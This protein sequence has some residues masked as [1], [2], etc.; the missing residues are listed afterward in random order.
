MSAEAPTQPLFDR[1]DLL[2]LVDS[3]DDPGLDAVALGVIGFDADQR[4]RRYNAFESQASGLEAGE[5]LGRPLFTEI[6]QCMNNYL[7]AERFEAART[8][9]H[10]LDE[11]ID[12]VLTWRM[13]P[14]KVRLRLLASP[15]RPLRY[16]VLQRDS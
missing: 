15:T 14:T 7:V 2:A 16:V 4:V 10:E 1:P 9:A 3:L 5:V 13:R 8:E 6:A 12:Y 11:T